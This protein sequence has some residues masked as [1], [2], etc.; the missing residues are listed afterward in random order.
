MLNVGAFSGFSGMVGG[1]LRIFNAEKLKVVHI[2]LR[3]IGNWIISFVD[4][5]FFVI[6]VAGEHGIFKEVFHKREIG[7]LRIFSVGYRMPSRLDKI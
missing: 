1:I 6:L 5:D 7:R 2:L 3:E 4:I